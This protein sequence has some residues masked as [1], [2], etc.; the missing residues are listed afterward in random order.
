M[1]DRA[2]A[3]HIKR[4]IERG[5]TYRWKNY[6]ERNKTP[7]KRETKRKRKRKQKEIKKDDIERGRMRQGM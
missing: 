2:K 1:E 7:I 6:N 4:D 3:K 5:E